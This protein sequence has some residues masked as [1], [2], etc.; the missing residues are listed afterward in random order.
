[1]D[2]SRFKGNTPSKNLK[3]KMKKGVSHFSYIKNK[4]KKLIPETCLEYEDSF[5]SGD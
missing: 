2:P 1:L 5:D 3:L 4:N